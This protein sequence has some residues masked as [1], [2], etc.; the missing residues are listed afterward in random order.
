MRYVGVYVCLSRG[1][2]SERGDSE[3]PELLFTVQA[4]LCFGMDNDWGR[5][6]SRRRR[7]S[8]GG[9]IECGS[10]GPAGAERTR[11]DAVS[12][13]CLSCFLSTVVV[14]GGLWCWWL[15][16]VLAEIS[17]CLHTLQDCG[18]RTASGQQRKRNETEQRLLSVSARRRKRRDAAQQRQ[19]PAME[20][21]E[22]SKAHE[23]VT[24]TAT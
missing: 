13:A 22:R 12:A 9:K 8:G 16:L 21:K 10:G 18:L 1:G 23:A 14:Y 5:S 7:E 2:R 20:D 6:G 11:T 24:Q 15:W 17:V 19:R 4:K 3:L